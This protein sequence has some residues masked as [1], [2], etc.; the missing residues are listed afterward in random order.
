MFPDNEVQKCLFL[1]KIKQKFNSVQKVLHM[2]L[3]CNVMDLDTIRKNMFTDP[4]ADYLTRIRNAN[5]AGHKVVDIPAS[6]LKKEM[7]KNALPPTPN[8]IN[9]VFT[10]IRLGL[11]IILM[12]KIEGD[13]EG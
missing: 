7:T 9:E 10:P 8:T 13:L 2:Y 11:N 12:R 5:S 6:N 1:T 4:I 3:L